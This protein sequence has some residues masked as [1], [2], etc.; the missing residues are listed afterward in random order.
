M[1]FELK[2]CPH[3][4][5][6]AGIYCG[7]GGAT[8]MCRKCY[9]RTSYVQDLTSKNFSAH[10]AIIDIVEIWNNRPKPAVPYEYEQ[11]WYC[12]KCNNEVSTGNKYCHECGSEL[13]WGNIS[14]ENK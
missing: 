6:D 4:G 9:M 2:E 5:S 8:I 10:P 12:D 7:N 1:T 13:N 11:I 14:K 3:C